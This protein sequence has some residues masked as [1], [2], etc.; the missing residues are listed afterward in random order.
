M[1]TKCS[2]V[3][4]GNHRKEANDLVSRVLLADD[5]AYEAHMALSVLSACFFTNFC[6]N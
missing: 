5:G 2:G 4:S 6:C 1:H 3:V